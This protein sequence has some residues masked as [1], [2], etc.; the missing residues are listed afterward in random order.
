MNS[1]NYTVSIRIKGDNPNHHLWN[2]NGTWFIHYTEHLPDFTKRR[3]RASLNTKCVV[4]AR[5]RRDEC[6]GGA[7]ADCA[8]AA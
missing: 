4:E 6:I 2:N 5:R 3:I 7:H 8:L 1:T